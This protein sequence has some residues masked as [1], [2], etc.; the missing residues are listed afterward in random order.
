MGSTGDRNCTRA[1]SGRF[2]RFFCRTA[3]PRPPRRDGEALAPV[4]RSLKYTEGQ[5]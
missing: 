5:P 1:G 4:T 3:L 2:L